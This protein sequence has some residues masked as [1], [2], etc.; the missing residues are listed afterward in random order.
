MLR[1]PLLVVLILCCG[2]SVLASGRLSLHLLG[3]TA[4][5]WTF[6][7]LTGMVGLAAVERP[8]PA[9]AT[10]DRFFAGYAPWL[11]WMTAFTA[12]VSTGSN[13]VMGPDAYLFWELAACAVLLWS[14]WIDYR[15]FGSA[16][17]LALHR[18][19]S[20]TL[21]GTIF[22]GAWIWTELAGL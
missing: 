21:F 1:R 14:C 5:Y 6:V 18:A 17:K 3:S 13:M 22:A 10:V 7:P 12:F 20:W 11:L 8:W 16:W 2:I 4:I 9:A 19:V 15:F